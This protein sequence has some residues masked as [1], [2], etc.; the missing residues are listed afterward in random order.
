VDG[1]T[2]IHNRRYLQE[3][4]ERELGR[5][6]RHARPLS[7]VL[8]DIDH[9]KNINDSHGHVAGDYVLSTLARRVHEIIR[10]EDVFA[11]YG[12]E[13]FAVIC[14]AIDLPKAN[15][16]AERLRSNIQATEFVFEQALIPVT[17]SLG[18]AGLPQV[19]VDDPLALVSAAD[20][21]LYDAKR[22]GRN[23]VE[24]AIG[25]AAGAASR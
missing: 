3:Y 25:P 21:A 9:F 23:R 24:L 16:F 12:G 22:G 8:F 11:R 5:A 15:L 6:A 17:V 14:R 7:L 20:Q 18:V 19:E 13:E 10:T 4:L 2:G 1:L